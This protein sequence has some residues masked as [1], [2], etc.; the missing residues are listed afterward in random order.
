M[1]MA[2]EGTPA[3]PPVAKRRRWLWPLLIASLALNLLVAGV[4][5]GGA[6][7]RGWHGPGRHGVSAFEGPIVRFVDRLPRERRNALGPLLDK[8]RG[9]VLASAPSMRQVRRDLADA[10]TA[11]PFDRKRFETALDSIG[12]AE[13]S[14]RKVAATSAGD[15]VS[16]LSADER[17][18][19]V[20]SMR[21]ALFFGDGPGD[22]PGK[23]P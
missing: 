20:R 7:I 17:R 16:A 11:E 1:T 6:V 5:I 14:A 12:A 21:R 4:L 10:L 3:T 23:G 19:L 8:H 9:N 15:L 18:G 22:G 13:T 2:P